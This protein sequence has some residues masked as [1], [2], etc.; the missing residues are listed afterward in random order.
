MLYPRS[1]KPQLKLNKKETQNLLLKFL[2]FIFFIIGW[3]LLS[4]SGL[5]RE[6]LFPPPTKVIPAL[7]DMIKSGELLSNLKSSFWRLA[8]GYTL[9]LC[10]G[11]W[12]GIL[13]GRNPWVK[14]TVGSLL[15]ALSSIPKVVLIPLAILWF[16]M[17]ETQKILLVAWG[18]FFPIW[19]NTQYG[20]EQIESEHLWTAK[21]LGL[22]S[23]QLLFHVII[24]AALPSIITGMRIGIST[25]IFSLAAA[26]MSGAFSG[27][28]HQVFYSHEMFQTDRMMAGVLFITLISFF[29]NEFFI[30]ISKTLIPWAP[31]ERK[32]TNE[33]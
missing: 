7:V 4:R 13:S 1:E 31:T 27:L 16:G 19:L 23:S 32:N 3:E 9:G 8:L 6:N 17:G 14:I 11:V 10:L 29:T 30:Y 25:A 24:P 15:N 33:D 5:Y 22:S 12:L 26:E 28:I 18:S 20:S 2:T 21:C